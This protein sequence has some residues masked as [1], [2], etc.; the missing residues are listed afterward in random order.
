[1]NG[2]GADRARGVMGFT[3]IELMVSLAIVGLIMVSV[4]T[5]FLRSQRTSQTMSDAVN[6]RQG[7]RGA[8]QLLE[9]E[10]RMAGSGWGRTPVCYWSNGKEDSL[11]AVGPGPGST[12]GCDSLTIV[13]GWT[14]N[15]SLRAGMPNPSSVIKVND[16]GEFKV[17]Q[18]CAITNGKSVHLF[19]ITAVTNPPGDIQHNPSSPVNPPGGV[20]LNNWPAG[21]Y[22]PGSQV[23]STTWVTYRVDSTTYGRPSLVRR[24][25][26]GTEQIVAHDVSRF[27]VRYRMQDGSITR[28]PGSLEM[29]EEILP[30]ISTSLARV[31]RPSLRD[32]AWASVRPRTF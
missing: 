11:F 26:G 9:R 19:Q 17:G 23:Y 18:L 16:A 8:I 6:L 12:D 2:R 24:V 7:A 32:S 13:G 15:T 22:G 31:D 5:A 20:N 27:E 1:M 21:G 3:L 14:A 29:I 28:K 25:V 30:V 4:F 10:L